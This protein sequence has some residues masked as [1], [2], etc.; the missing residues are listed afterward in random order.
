MIPISECMRACNVTYN[1][2]QTTEFLRSGWYQT[3]PF[4]DPGDVGIIAGKY[5]EA[6]K[7]K[8]PQILEGHIGVALTAKQ[9]IAAFSSFSLGDDMLTL[10]QMIM[11]ANTDTEIV[12]VQSLPC[13]YALLAAIED[14]GRSCQAHAT[15]VPARIS[16]P[17]HSASGRYTVPLDVTMIYRG[18]QKKGGVFVKPL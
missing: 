5:L 6:G 4:S 14:I 9:R 12:R 1:T 15:Q 2:Q 18:Y 7:W 11:L 8:H 3:V 17:H 16:V 13:E 10:R